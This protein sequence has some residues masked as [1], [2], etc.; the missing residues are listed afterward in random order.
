[1]NSLDWT[2][3]EARDFAINGIR[4]IFDIKVTV[5][6]YFILESHCSGSRESFYNLICSFS[7]GRII[8][9]TI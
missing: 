4:E 2:G 6:I 9:L 7:G 8:R 1:M 3:F 5:I